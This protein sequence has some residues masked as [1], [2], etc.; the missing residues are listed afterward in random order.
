MPRP[1]R[2]SS[3]TPT[4]RPMPGS[5]T[6]TATSSGSRDPNSRRRPDPGSASAGGRARLAPVPPDVGSAR[7][8]HRTEAAHV[9]RDYEVHPSL[10]TADL[11][12]AKAWYA[13]KLD[14]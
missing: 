1:S 8:E 7:F 12:D 6:P 9:L 11:A 13:D 2:A 5:R 10:A 4:G 3:S 14:L